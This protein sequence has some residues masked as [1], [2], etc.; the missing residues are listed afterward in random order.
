VTEN[1]AA[2]PEKQKA[3]IQEI[4]SVLRSTEAMAVQFTERVQERVGEQVSPAD[5]LSVMKKM[6]NKRLSMSKVVDKVRRQQSS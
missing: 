5:V 6:S 1:P 4:A 3:T 2:R